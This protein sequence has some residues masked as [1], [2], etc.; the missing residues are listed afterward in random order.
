MSIFKRRKKTIEP[1]E[2]ERAE[3][4]ELERVAKA[5]KA[6]LERSVYRVDDVLERLR[7]KAERILNA[8]NSPR[9]RVIK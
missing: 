2:A 8:E 7:L 6:D 4:E 9:L 3:R 5:M 1:S